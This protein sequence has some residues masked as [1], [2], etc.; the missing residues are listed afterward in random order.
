MD[1]INIARYFD[2]DAYLHLPILK[3]SERVVTRA[4]IKHLEWSI[5]TVGLDLSSIQ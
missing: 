4:D 3:F 1:T 5:F 2:D